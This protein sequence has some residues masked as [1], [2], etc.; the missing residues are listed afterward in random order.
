MK[1]LNLKK[2]GKRAGIIVLALI[3]IDLVAGVATVAL[4]AEFLKR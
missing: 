3:A 4:G 2:F 1:R